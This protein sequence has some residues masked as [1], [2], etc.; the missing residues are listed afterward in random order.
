MPRSLTW[1]LTIAFLLV[2]ATVSIL[3]VISLRFVN[4]AQFNTLIV[5]QL[6]TDFQSL[7]VKY[8]QANGSWTGIDE[9][10]QQ[11]TVQAVG[12]FAAP[13]TQ[14][15]VATQSGF[16]GSGPAPGG[17][18]P[19]D[20]R[21]QF[22]LADAQGIVIIS[23]RPE[24]PAGTK[25]SAE[26][27]AQGEPVTV[28]GAVVGTILTAPRPPNLSAEE[29]QYLERLNIALL[30]A[31]LGAF[32]VALGMGVWLART[33][34]HPLKALTQ[35][36]QRMAEGDLEQQ[37]DQKSRD[38]IGELAAAFNTMSHAVA[39]AN[40]ARQ[41]LAADVAH[42]LRTPLTVISGYIESLRDGVLAP[43][44]KR[45]S[46][47]YDE[48]EHLQHLVDDL[49]VLSEADAGDLK[50]NRQAVA[51]ADFLRQLCATFEQ[52][53]LQKSITLELDIP[54]SIPPVRI[55]ETRMAQVIANLI[56]NALRYTPPQGRIVLGAREEADE[57]VLTV[58]DTGAGISEEDLPHIF[59][60]FY[61]ADDSGVSGLGLAIARALVAA[62]GGTL[63]VESAKGEG[64]LM[65]IRLPRQA[66]AASTAPKG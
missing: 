52:Q 45:L 61:R 63:E 16:S 31:G 39:Q 36:A 14:A 40:R 20:W 13:A 15:M 37:V 58:R 60:R 12:T 43:S 62:H 53:A 51:P 55:D 35:A 4:P 64:T 42:E 34:T 22:G 44:P 65:R 50:V 57:V 59:D 56:S 8:Y 2:A 19:R 11:Q 24:K 46:V 33:L 29:S 3:P 7:L 30:L 49:R 10:L 47:I 41:K 23:V 27:L 32:L 48:I 26:L 21:N 66:S 28:E 17:P 18:F 1:K 9:Y 54:A 38:E 25:L 5:S 6:R